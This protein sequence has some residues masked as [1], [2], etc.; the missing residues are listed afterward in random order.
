M[1]KQSKMITS[2]FTALLVVISSTVN[3]TVLASEQANTG[4]NAAAEN[5]T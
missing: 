4:D 3:W 5:I 2:V 1:K